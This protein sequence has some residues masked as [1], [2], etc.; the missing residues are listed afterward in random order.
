MTKYK[1]EE[2]VHNLESPNQIVPEIIKLLAPKSV[3]D[4]GCGIGTFLNVF[5]KNHVQDVL[6]IDGSWVNRDLLHKHIS[7]EEFKECNL[8]EPIQLEKKYD[9]ALSL[10]VA[11]HLSEKSAKAFVKSLV[12]AGK[13]VVF[14]AAIPSQGGQNH[15]NEQWLSYWETL[16]LEN[17]YVL[18]DVIRPILWDNPKIFCWYKQNMVLFGPKH[19]DFK[20]EV[21]YCPIKNIVHP[22]LFA[23]KVKIAD[24]L[25]NPS[26]KAGTKIFA[27]SIIGAKN[28]KK[29]NR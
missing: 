22:E 24:E 4:V 23:I 5:K 3:V 27:K 13:V 12:N 10:E 1:H 14:S 6:G 19:I 18:H 11:E 25:T 2:H 9:L 21:T 28:I 29:L 15:I 7:E 16:F 8:E 26:I 20:T 17:G